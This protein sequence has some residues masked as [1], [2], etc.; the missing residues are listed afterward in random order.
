MMGIGGALLLVV[1]AASGDGVEPAHGRNAVYVRALEKGVE[2]EGETVTLPAPKIVDKQSADQERAALKAIAGSDR[3]ADELLRDSVTAPY[4]LKVRDV[5][6]ASGTI[7]VADVWFVIHAELNAVD[8][9]E[10]ADR[11]SGGEVEAGNMAFRTKLL[12]ADQAR[13]EGV[14]VGPKQEGVETWFAHIEGRLL[15]RIAIDVTNRV[16][17]TNSGDSIVV[18]S[19]TDPAF[20]KNGSPR[21]SWAPIG[22]SASANE[23]EKPRPYQG[24]ISY[25][26]ISRL[27]V[28]PKA[29][30]VELHTA[31]VEPKGWFDGE[32]ILRS[33]FSV[34]AQS[35]IRSL[36][37][38]LLKKKRSE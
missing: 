37:R 31:F 27:A 36:R 21:N 6:T 16:T 12:N 38:E 22:K 3:G 10:A 20:K 33:K 34:I 4:I 26:K 9:K 24:G 15:D 35:E 30:L 29:L 18:A 28:K 5:K 7:R 17:A 32:P 25:G 2:F 8:P 19:W 1:M 13:G 23:A 14:D 11:V